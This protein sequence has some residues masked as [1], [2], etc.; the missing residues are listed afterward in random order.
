MARRRWHWSRMLLRL[1]KII[2]NDQLILAVLALAAGALVGGSVI[3]FRLLIGLFQ[4]VFSVTAQN[5]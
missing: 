2:R 3:V 5:F 1:R 4:T